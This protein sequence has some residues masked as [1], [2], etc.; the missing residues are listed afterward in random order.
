MQSLAFLL[1]GYSVFAAPVLAMT[2]LQAENAGG[3]SVSRAMGVILLLS[4]AG[5][6][7]IHFTY[8]RQGGGLIQGPLYSLLLFTVAPAFYLFSNPLLRARPQGHPL[9]W[10]HL[11]PPL[12]APFLP[13]RAALPFS[14]ALGS[15]YLLWLGRSIHALRAQRRRFRLELLLIA[16]LFFVALVVL[17]LGLALPLVPERLFFSLYAIAIGCA[18]LL[19]DL[20]LGYAPRIS[21]EVVEAARETYAVSTLTNL[22]CGALLDQLE[23]L[24]AQERLYLNPDLDLPGLAGRMG[25]SVH[26]LSELI[27]SRMGKGF[28]RY[29]REYRVAAAQAML[30]AEPSASVLAVGLSCGFTSQSN[31]YEAF[32]EITGMTPG[33]FRR[34]AART[35]PE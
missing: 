10:L 20:L 26:Q 32:R 13:H 33:Q 30:R 18:L 19:A 25:I 16:G 7:L 4:L 12:L 23:L 24:M 14:F 1:I 9:Q 5:L 29:I 11:L 2:H 6:Q 21:T 31:F 34:I 15:L 3:T 22:D 27:N 17:A 8:L 35:A 28:S